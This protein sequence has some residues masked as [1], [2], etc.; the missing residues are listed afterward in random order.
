M[1][2]RAQIHKRLRSFDRKCI[3]LFIVSNERDERTQISA[4]PQGAKS[5]AAVCVVGSAK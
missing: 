5:K 3:L 4:R 1:R 2:S